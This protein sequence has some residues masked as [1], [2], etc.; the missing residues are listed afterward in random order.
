MN[1][2]EVRNRLR[3]AIHQDPEVVGLQ[4]GDL[5]SFRI[6]DH[7]VNLHQ[8]G[9]DAEYRGRRRG[10]F[11]CLE[12]TPGKKAEQLSSEPCATLLVKDTS[13]AP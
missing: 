12:Q 4:I 11:L 6:G 9:T 2:G 1:V 7:R 8:R 5:Q 3:F 10:G 13:D